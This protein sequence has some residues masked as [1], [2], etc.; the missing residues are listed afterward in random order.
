MIIGHDRVSSK[1]QNLDAQ[2]DTLVATGA[3]CSCSERVNGAKAER[4]ISM[5]MLALRHGQLQLEPKNTSAI[6]HLC[7]PY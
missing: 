4:P 1:D 2:T 3:E 6:N 5:V 7:A